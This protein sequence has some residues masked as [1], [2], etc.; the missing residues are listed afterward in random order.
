MARALAS[1]LEGQKDSQKK[2][3][4]GPIRENL[5]PVES[6]QRADWKDGSNSFVWT[7][8]DM[9]SNLL[10][11]L[12]R[13]C[14]DG[15]R[16]NLDYLPLASAYTAKPDDIAAFLKGGVDAQRIGDL[17]LPLSL[18]RYKRQPETVQ[19][20]EQRLPVA[21]AVMKLTLL[22]SEFICPAF[23]ENKDIRMEPQMLAMLRA[24][25]VKD[26]YRVAYRRLIASGL[27]PLS[28]EPGIADRSAPGRRLAAA[29]LFPLSTGA[30]KALA[31][32]ALYRPPSDV[33]EQLR[34]PGDSQDS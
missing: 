30:H 3:E 22:P 28:A 2:A 9:F 25:R 15:R 14:M 12:E 13:R 17:V 6:R 11:V 34:S 33:E 4:V 23:G 26:A 10:A 29:L 24:G 16:S 5:E 27:R 7:A 18:V 8:R 20:C 31:E 21:Y 1:I 32:R 19:T